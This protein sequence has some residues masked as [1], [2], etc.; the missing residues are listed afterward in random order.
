MQPVSESFKDAVRND[1]RRH[2]LVEVLD[3]NLNPVEG[4]VLTG[5]EGVAISG[6]VL[7]D[8][9]RDVRRTM[10]LDLVNRD[11][12][13]TPVAPGGLVYWDRLARVSRGIELGG[14]EQI[15]Y[16]RK[17]TFVMDRPQVE[18]GTAGSILSLSGADQMS[19][20]MRSKFTAPT[21]YASATR[22]RDVASDI[23]IDGGWNPAHLSLDDGGQ[24]LQAARTW[25]IADERIKALRDLQNSFALEV[26]ADPS[27]MGIMRPVRDPATLPV[28]WTFVAGEDAVMLGVSKRWSI[29]RLYNH[30]LVTG[31]RS[32]ASPVYAEAKDTNPASPTYINGPLGDRLF[33]YTSS[34]IYTQAQAQAVANMLLHEHALIEEEISLPHIP[35]A[36]LD[37]GD[38]VEIIEDDSGSAGRYMIDTL[39]M[40]MEEGPSTLTTHRLRSLL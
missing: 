30:I 22:V 32:D 28:A 21:T 18:V 36:F 12:E 8:R 13:L 29:D 25:E 27:G 1:H 40:P 14:P 5:R 10:S 33:M 3:A 15:E 16:A 35:L 31:E 26:F 23:L 19:R 11:G 4:G 9:H 39:E 20:I 34:M 17:G 37:E 38:V 6:R 7:A 2:T 24:T